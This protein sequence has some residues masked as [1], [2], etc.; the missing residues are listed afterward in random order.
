MNCGTQRARAFRDW[1]SNYGMQV[2]SGRPTPRPALLLAM[3]CA[4]G[5][6][7]S[8]WPDVAEAYAHARRDGKR[9]IVLKTGDSG[10]LRVDLG[11]QG[12]TEMRYQHGEWHQLSIG[13]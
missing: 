4:V 6:C 1:L 8:R 7:C 13:M 2:V 12:M 3:A 9:T 11:V 5:V 10:A